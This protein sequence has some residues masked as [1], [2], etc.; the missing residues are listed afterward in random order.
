MNETKPNF[1]FICSD[2]HS[3][4]QLGCYGNTSIITPAMDSIAN[5]GIRFDS[6]YSTNPICVPARASMVTGRRPSEIGCYDNASPYTGQAPS[7]GHRLIEADIDVITVGKLHFR[8]ADDD[9]GFPDQRVPL[10]LRDG[11]GDIY[12]ALRDPRAQKLGLAQYVYEAGPGESS[13]ISYDSRITK[14]ALACLD[15]RK[16]SSKQWFLYVGYTMPH[17]PLISPQETWDLYEGMDLP[18]PKQY[19]E[20]DMSRYEWCIHHRRYKGMEK[21]IDETVIRNAIRAYYGMCTFLDRQVAALLARLKQNGLADNTVIMYST[22]HGEML[23]NHG[24]WYKNSMFE[25]SVGIPLMIRGPGIKPGVVKTPVSLLDLY[26]TIIQ[27]MGRTQSPQDVSLP[28]RSLLDIAGEPYDAERAVVSEYF[29]SACVSG[30]FM[31]RKG[32]FKYIHYVATAPQLFDLKTDPSELHDLAPNPAYGRILHDMEKTLH[33][34]GDPAEIDAK[35]RKAQDALL[36]QYGG[37]EKVL[38]NFE[39]V[40]YTPAPI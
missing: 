39:P 38:T 12:G 14:E 8:N 6:A 30:G 3:K 15:E 21:E 36:A 1:L 18:M 2:Q 25:E 34:H 31:V 10:H 29:G 5:K 7:F 33:Q 28:G 17:I 23:G 16:E 37:R 19:K 32:R 27:C 9:T 35:C 13:Y 24:L 40:L 22:D 4:F 26:P 11:I 20:Q